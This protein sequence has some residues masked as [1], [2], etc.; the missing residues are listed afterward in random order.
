MTCDP[1][2]GDLAPSLRSDTELDEIVAAWPHLG[3]ST[4]ATLRDQGGP[5]ASR[6]AST[7]PQQSPGSDP[8]LIAVTEAWP[9]LAEHVR[10]TIR[11]LVD[12]SR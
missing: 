7:R 3:D 6:I 9:R 10:K 11:T 8:D 4:R 5:T 12:L 1:D 2:A